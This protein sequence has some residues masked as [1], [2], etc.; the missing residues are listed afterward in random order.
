MDGVSV[1]DGR[2]RAPANRPDGRAAESRRAADCGRRTLPTSPPVAVRSLRWI[3]LGLDVVRGHRWRGSSPCSFRVSSRARSAGA[4]PASSPSSSS[5]PCRRCSSSRP[6]A[7]TSRGCAVSAPSRR[8]GSHGPRCSPA[9]IACSSP[10]SSPPSSTIARAALGAFLTFALLAL[11][12]GVYGSWLRRGRTQ[13]V[14]SAGPSCSSAPVP[15]PASSSV[16]SSST[17][18]SGSA[19]PA[20]SVR[21]RELR[22]LEL[23]GRARRRL[24]R[25]APRPRAGARQRRHRRDERRPDRRAQPHDAGA[26]PPRRARAPL[27]RPARHRPSPHPRAA[28]RARAALLP[29]AAVARPVAAVGEAR[30]RRRGLGRD[31]RPAQPDPPARAR[32]PSSC[33]TVAR[34]SSARP[35][36]VAT[37]CRFTLLKLRTMVT[38]AEEQLVDLSV[39]NQRTGPALQ[40]RARSPP[41]AGRSRPRAHE[42]R[43]AARS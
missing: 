32:S 34:C 5:S 6:S 31:A 29:R 3:L 33:A 2:R 21:R 24:R 23:E 38:D 4:R 39:D 16:C 13:R 42:H 8:L 27:E 30:P 11:A 15:R 18:S 25:R 26:A 12:R 14:G 41:H 20:S 35:G 22:G 10:V 43:R 1:R 9:S 7:S 19:S 37:A 40:A 28:A 36:S 17:P